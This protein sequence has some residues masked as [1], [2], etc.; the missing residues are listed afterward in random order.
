[1]QVVQG[2]ARPSRPGFGSSG[3]KLRVL[4]NH[5]EVLSKLAESYHYDV[6]INRL[7]ELPCSTL[8]ACILG[9]FALKHGSALLAALLL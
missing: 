1:M 2:K 9:G 5:F 4:A 6:S 7:R 3:R 8:H